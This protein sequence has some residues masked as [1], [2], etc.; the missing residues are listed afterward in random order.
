MLRDM[1]SITWRHGGMREFIETCSLDVLMV[2]SHPGLDD[3]TLLS[4]ATSDGLLILMHPDR[5]DD[6]GT[7]VTVEVGTD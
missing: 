3:E 5:Q 6:E 1:Q 2:N 4:M 7:G